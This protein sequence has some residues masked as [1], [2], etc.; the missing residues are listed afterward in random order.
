MAVAG[1]GG[2]EPFLELR[3]RLPTYTEGE[4]DHAVEFLVGGRMGD[5]LDANTSA[6]VRLGIDPEDP[7]CEG[8]QRMCNVM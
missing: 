3:K 2:S 5:I 1:G 6:A 7:D 8:F 4:G